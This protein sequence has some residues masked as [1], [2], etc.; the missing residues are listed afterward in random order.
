[1][2]EKNDSGSAMISI[3][4][5]LTGNTLPVEQCRIRYFQKRSLETDGGSSRKTAGS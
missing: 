4:S 2:K 5:P 3:Y 1:M